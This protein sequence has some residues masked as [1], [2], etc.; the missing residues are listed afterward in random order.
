MDGWTDGTN[1]RGTVAK[2]TSRTQR[3]YPA[4]V[5]SRIA[6]ECV[7]A[8]F[9]TRGEGAAL[10][11]LKRWCVSQYLGRIYGAIMCV[12]EDMVFAELSVA[13]TSDR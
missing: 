9:V 1:A 12:W 5:P 4:F 8:G 2:L 10:E 3:R 6:N 13:A 11:F 7:E